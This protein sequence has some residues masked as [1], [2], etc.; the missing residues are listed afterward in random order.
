MLPLFTHNFGW[1]WPKHIL[2]SGSGHFILAGEGGDNFGG[3]VD[4]FWP[5]RGVRF[6]F[7]WLTGKQ[8]LI[9]VIKRVYS[10]KNNWI[11]AYI[12]YELKGG[13]NFF[14][15]LKGVGYFRARKGKVVIFCELPTKFS[16]PSPT[17][18]KWPL[19]Y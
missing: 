6:F 8:Y 13:V 9:N 18:I 11:W 5:R 19:P 14:N 10:W 7:S 2:F 4:F 1:W 15:A 12:K 3:G 16:Q 17:C